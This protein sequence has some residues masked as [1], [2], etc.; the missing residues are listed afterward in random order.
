MQ[1]AIIHLVPKANITVPQDKIKV[2]A[3]I[4]HA[5]FN[6]R[7]KTLNNSL[8]NVIDLQTLEILNIDRTKRAENVTIDE[9][10]ALANLNI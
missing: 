3:K 5:A 6:K 10:V 8:N 2:F 9:Y 1:S 4:V 7:R